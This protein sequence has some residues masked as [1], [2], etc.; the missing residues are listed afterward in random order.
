MKL[1]DYLKTH[2]NY[3]LTSRR[4][5]NLHQTKIIQTHIFYSQIFKAFP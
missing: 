3:V 2:E 5:N 1:K 4:A